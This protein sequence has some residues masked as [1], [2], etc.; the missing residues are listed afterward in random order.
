[1]TKYKEREPYVV[2]SCKEV[3]KNYTVG[4]E[5]ISTKILKPVEFVNLRTGDVVSAADAG[6]RGIWESE[7]L[8]SKNIQQRDYWM[9]QIDSR[10]L[11]LAEQVLM[12]R[13]DSGGMLC[14]LDDLAGYIADVHDKRKDKIKAS[15]LKF[16]GILF[17]SVDLELRECFKKYGDNELN[18]VFKKDACMFITAALKRNKQTCG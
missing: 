6:K 4:T 3:T 8:I 17:I 9:K 7:K 5:K 1:M 14:C 13:S 11:E 12:Y 16:V 15:I 18:G 2:F 10:L